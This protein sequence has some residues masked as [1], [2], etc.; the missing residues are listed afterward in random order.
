MYALTITHNIPFG[1][2]ALNPEDSMS[3][4]ITALS[5]SDGPPPYDPTISFVTT[6]SGE[7]FARFT[8]Y[9]NTISVLER[10]SNEF[11][12]PTSNLYGR[13][14]Y[15]L[16]NNAQITYNITEVDGPIDQI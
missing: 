5:N 10:I 13:H 1:T 16:K 4:Y 6:D 11:Q 14:A 7:V 9:S 8:R 3:E 12:N 2:F 15:A